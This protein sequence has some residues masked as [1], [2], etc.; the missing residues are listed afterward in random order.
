[1]K[2]ITEIDLEEQR[3]IWGTAKM[4]NH[5]RITEFQ[6]EAHAKRWKDDQQASQPTAENEGSADSVVHDSGVVQGFTNGHV[7]VIRHGCKEKKFSWQVAQ[8][9]AGPGHVF[10]HF[11][12]MA[13]ITHPS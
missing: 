12:Q 1:M 5:I 3:K 7:A 8:Q 11:A 4:I 10:L 13:A 2:N 6:L 9:E